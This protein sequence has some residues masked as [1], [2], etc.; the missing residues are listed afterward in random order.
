MKLNSNIVRDCISRRVIHCMFC[1]LTS[2]RQALFC[3]IEMRTGDV[4][5]AVWGLEPHTESA[6]MDSTVDAQITSNDPFLTLKNLSSFVKHALSAMTV[7]QG[8]SD[9]K[10]DDI[11]RRRWVF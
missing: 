9:L 4:V 11:G 6:L 3:C 2:Q 10:V 5:G 8:K 7:Q 1:Q